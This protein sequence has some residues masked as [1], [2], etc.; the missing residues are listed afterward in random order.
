MPRGNSDP[1][2]WLSSERH[3]SDTPRVV[4]RDRVGVQ[5]GGLGTAVPALA[6]CAPSYLDVSGGA[7]YDSG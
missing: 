6:W 1:G 3:R 7:G 5:P 2:R 4:E